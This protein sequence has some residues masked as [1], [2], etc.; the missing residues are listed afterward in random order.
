MADDLRSQIWN[1]LPAFFDHPTDLETSFKGI[2]KLLGTGLND[3][4]DLRALICRALQT[5]KGWYNGGYIFPDG[6][7]SRMTF[8]SS[9]PR[10]PHTCVPSVRLG[11][12]TLSVL[13]HM[14]SA[15]FSLFALPQHP[16][17][18][19]CPP[20]TPCLRPAPPSAP[21]SSLRSAVR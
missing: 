4:P 11:S 5:G 10:P 18:I 14:R 16:S 15:Q 19:C 20:G 13:E 3:R 7:R 17:S 8:R 9:V 6:F 21:A 12:R 1:T 2:A